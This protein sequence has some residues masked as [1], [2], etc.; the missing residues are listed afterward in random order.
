MIGEVD[1]DG[2]LTGDNIAY[3]Y[4]DKETALIGRF[5]N[6]QL[7]RARAA[8][9]HIKHVSEVTKGCDA[10]K[11]LPKFTYRTDYPEAV[12]IDVSTHDV[13]SLQ[14]LL[15][16]VYERDRVCVKKSLIEDAGE[17]LF[18]KVALKEDE[19]ASFYNGIRLSHDEVD[20]RDW[21][22]N[23]N[24]LSLDE[25]TVIDVPVECADVGVYCATLG[26]KANHS[27]VPN[28]KYDVFYHPRY[29]YITCIIIITSS[30]SLLHAFSL[31]LVTLNVYGH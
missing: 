13:L 29:I 19:V 25:D 20:S 17:G 1:S 16:D 28:S 27:S 2:R 22:A 7:V 23:G 15:G 6:G 14:P 21:S 30:L 9:L 26:H 8:K 18:A 3:V 12:C 5:Q 31:D 4:P 24:T 10:L 11:M